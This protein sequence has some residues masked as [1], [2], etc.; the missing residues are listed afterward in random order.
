MLFTEVMRKYSTAMVPWGC[1][2]DTDHSYGDLYNRVCGDLQNRGAQVLEIGVLHGAFMQ[3]VAEF[4]P[5]ACV[6]GMDIAPRLWAGWNWSDDRVRVVQVDATQPHAVDVFEGPFDL[7]VEDASHVPH[8]QARTL[9]LFAPLLKPGGVYIIEDIHPD[10]AEYVRE[11]A[12]ALA[13]KHGLSLE[14]MDLR[15]VKGRFDDIVAVL[16]RHALKPVVPA[17]PAATET[18]RDE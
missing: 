9:D 5:D 14:W 8:E 13:E 16:R 2:K 12:S 7:I 17:P 4:L 11:H 6:C 10:A 1:D 18:S 15:H 3:A